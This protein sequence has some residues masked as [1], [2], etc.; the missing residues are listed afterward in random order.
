MDAE[1]AHPSIHRV[2]QEPLAPWE[3]KQQTTLKSCSFELKKTAKCKPKGLILV[4]LIHRENSL[5]AFL[6]KL[7][8]PIALLHNFTYKQ[9]SAP[10]ASHM[11]HKNT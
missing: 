3:K 1:R 9:V 6:L 2:F 10:M 11:H 5:S 8:L 7:S 4:T